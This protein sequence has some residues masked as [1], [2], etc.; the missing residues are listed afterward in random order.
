MAFSE[1]ARRAG[2]LITDNS[3]AIMTAIGVTGTLTAVYLTGTATFKAA[4]ILEQERKKV[5]TERLEEEVEHQDNSHQIFLFDNNNYITPKRQVELTWQ[6]YIPAATT[7]AL[8]IAAIILANRVSTRRAAALAAAY[9]IA[10]RGFEEFKTKAV[11]RLGEARMQEV[12]DEVAKDRV[13]RNPVMDRE[14]IITGQGN[15]LFYESFT[16]RYF[17]NNVQSID[18]AVNELNAQII[19]DNYA[20]LTDF[21]YK[22]GL[23]KTSMSD[24]VGWQAPTLLKVSYSTTMTDE[25]NARPCMV[26]DFQAGPIRDYDSFN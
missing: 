9:S 18:R 11:E 14:V 4:L 22:I 1:F 2:K 26:I 23:A 24:E 5:F 17:E 6:L 8:T 25:D 21:Y 10:E 19:S 13:R 3:P 7:L 20:S 15:V 16:G 12:Q